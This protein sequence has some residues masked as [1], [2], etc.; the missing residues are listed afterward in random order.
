MPA[1]YLRVCKVAD[2]LLKICC[3]VRPIPRRVAGAGQVFEDAVLAID[4]FDQEL[5]S[6][7]VLNTLASGPFSTPYQAIALFRILSQT[8]GRSRA[9]DRLRP[10]RPGV[11][12]FDQTHR[13]H[14]EW[15]AG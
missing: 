1:R 10:V 11:R 13:I 15:P 9:P 8:M 14:R 12:D 3:R 7:V 6:S 5:R 2:Q 4:Q